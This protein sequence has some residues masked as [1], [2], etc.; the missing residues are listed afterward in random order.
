TADFGDLFNHLGKAD[1]EVTFKLR[2]DSEPYAIAAPRKIPIPLRAPLKQ[3][4]GKLESEGIIVKVTT[5]TQWC[6]PIVVVGK[7][8][9][10]KD[11]TAQTEIRLC[12]DFTVANKSIEREFFPIQDPESILAQLGSAK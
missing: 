5:P 1:T 4:L 2:P 3:L 10:G 6:S 12:V 9:I 7:K 11:K 8:P